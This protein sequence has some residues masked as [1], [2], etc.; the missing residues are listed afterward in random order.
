MSSAIFERNGL[1]RI[2]RYNISAGSVINLL[3]G[4][5]GASGTAVVTSVLLDTSGSE[6]VVSPHIS[7]C[8]FDPIFSVLHVL[9]F[10]EHE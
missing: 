6:L 10:Q 5:S 4:F 3:A 8:M 1:D 9:L 2:D 7:F